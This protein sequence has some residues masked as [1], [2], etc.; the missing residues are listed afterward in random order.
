MVD[1]TVYVIVLKFG[2][3]YLVAKL[4]SY[5]F[6][7]T[8]NYLLSILWVFESSR[9]FRKEISV[10]FFISLLGL[11]WTELLLYFFVDTL[12]LGA[13]VANIIATFLVLFW[14]F[15]ARKMWAFK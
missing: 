2:V 5:C 3:H 8:W 11:L 10:V 15:G 13:I 1:F 4:I 7:F 14:N 9:A 12:S 6:G